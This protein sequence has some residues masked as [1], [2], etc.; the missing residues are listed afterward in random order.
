MYAGVQTYLDKQFT[1]LQKGYRLQT[2][3]SIASDQHH[4]QDS[5]F[6]VIAFLNGIR[7]QSANHTTN[8]HYLTFTFTEQYLQKSA[9]VLLFDGCAVGDIISLTFSYVVY[10]PN[11]VKFGSYGGTI[12]E[13]EFKGRSAKNIQYLF[14]QYNFIALY[15]LSGLKTSKRN[16][17]G[18]SLQ[19]ELTQNYTMTYQINEW[20]IIKSLEITYIVM[21]VMPSAICQKASQC[22]STA[23]IY[24]YQTSCV[25]ACPNN[26]KPMSFI[27]GAIECQECPPNQTYSSKTNSCQCMQGYALDN[28]KNC[29]AAPRNQLAGV[30]HSRSSRVDQ[31]DKQPTLPS[32]QNCLTLDSIQQ[33]N[34]NLFVK[35]KGSGVVLSDRGSNDRNFI[36]IVF[37]E[38]KAAN[39]YYCNR[40]SVESEYYQCLLLFATNVPRGSFS[41]RFQS[42]LSK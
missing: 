38:G 32:L 34:K 31:L 20:E 30:T 13:Y 26:T 14:A 7:Y 10:P 21:G 19:T 23:Q 4:L 35:L 39:S 1:K 17:S 25:S 40:C 18:F 5:Q 29:I 41:L 2:G 16:E 28:H 42:T 3:I 22:Q 9:I 15:G 27:D 37:E 12:N 24:I 6:V 33:S 36:R 8:P 11:V